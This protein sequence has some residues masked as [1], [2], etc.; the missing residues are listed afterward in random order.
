MRTR[1]FV[2]T[3]IAYIFGFAVIFTFLHFEQRIYLWDFRGYWVQYMDLA[4]LA[5]SSPIY[6]IKSI[7]ESVQSS[8]YNNLIVA[9]PALLVFITGDSREAFLYSIFVIYLIPFSILFGYF[10]SN[11]IHR[12]Y[13]IHLPPLSYCLLALFCMPIWTTLLRGEPDVAGLIAMVS[14]VGAIFTLRADRVHLSRAL[15][16][17]L[18]IWAAFLARRWYAFGMMP[19]AFFAPLLTIYLTVAERK[20]ALSRSIAFTAINYLIAGTLALFLLAT[21]QH[22][23]VVRVLSTSYGDVYDAYQ[24]ELAFHLWRVYS[25]FG[26]LPLTLALAGSVI[27][28]KNRSAR[29]YLLYAIAC[30]LVTYVSFIRTQQFE[31]HHFLMISFWLLFFQ[32][33]GLSVFAKLN[34]RRLVKLVTIYSTVVFALPWA[35]MASGLKPSVFV[36]PSAIQ[37]MRVENYNE[38]KRLV[39]DLVRLGD[40]KIAVI[41]SGKNFN[42]SMMMS[43]SDEKLVKQFIAI[44]HVDKMHGFMPEPFSADYIVLSSPVATHLPRGQEVIRIYSE[45]FSRFISEGTYS[46]V[47]SDYK[48]AGG[49]IAKVFK[50][51]FPVSR[52]Q[53]KSV[54]EKIYAVYPDWRERYEN[55]LLLDQMFSKIKLGDKWGFVRFDTKNNRIELHP[56]QTT[57]TSFSIASG[58][59]LAVGL[60]RPCGG[61]DGVIVGIDGNGNHI[62]RSVT[63]TEPI[64]FDTSK[65]AGSEMTITVSNNT[66][67][68]CDHTY[69]E[70]AKPQ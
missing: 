7:R 57:P 14:A 56:G 16:I 18:S 47:G 51:N 1:N 64:V 37:P 42:D 23:L 49:M 52:E 46:Q 3:I 35:V 33:I 63:T 5:S 70:I 17:G 48:L 26:I 68:T 40:I 20:I 21:L 32:A 55:S 2:P 65:F 36:I 61:S 12:V 39:D 62:E 10:A 69:V 11:F 44:P 15:L 59:N 45:S 31:N 19:I 25:H 38:Y 53:I 27:G 50:R 24:R 29:P 9:I 58:R 60:V 22:D 66:N 30:C 54:L 67:P 34:S 4:K 6:F 43:L 13:S 41:G 28:L 8:D